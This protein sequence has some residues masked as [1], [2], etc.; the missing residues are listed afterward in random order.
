[1]QILFVGDAPEPE[2]VAALASVPDGVVAAA[3]GGDALRA[4]LAAS[5][6]ILVVDARAGL[7]ERLDSLDAV[8]ADRPPTTPRVVLV[9]R[10]EEADAVALLHPGLDDY[11][12]GDPEHFP[13][14]RS[15]IRRAAARAR[16]LRWTES[17]YE[18]AVAAL[19]RSEA[20]YRTLF[21]AHPSPLWVYDERTLAFLA[22]NQAAVERYGYSRD[23]FLAMT[24]RDIRPEEDREALE[25]HVAA[26]RPARVKAGGWRHRKKDGT[27][28]DVEVSSH[29]IPFDG[30]VARLVVTED[31]TERRRSEEERA[32]L[33]MAVEQA[34][35]AI[36][37]TDPDGTIVYVNPAF[38][39]VT[40]YH[41]TEAR[42]R[43]PRILKSGRQDAAFYAELWST[44]TS[45]ETW[46]G[47]LTNRRKD[48]SLY[49]AEAAISPVRD[50]AG[51][52]VNYVA[53]ERDVTHERHLE[54]QFLQSQKMEAVGRLAG[55]IAH[56]FNNLLNVITG[57]GE[58]LRRR[59]TPEDP[60]GGKLDQILKAADRAAGLVRQ[61]LA[62][63]RRQVLQPK[64][65]DLGLVV[66]DLD[67]MLRRLIGED[68][69]LQCLTD[70][71]LG[72]VRADPGQIEQVLMNLVVNARDAMPGG[73]KITIETRNLDV[74][75]TEARLR[76]SVPPGPYV[77]LAV[78]DTGTGM[79]EET[80]AHVFEPFFT[81]KEPG[82]GT[83][84]GLSTVYGI[85]R[86]SGG[87]ISVYSE[88]GGGTTFKIYLPR[89]DEPAV[90]DATPAP[91]RA[92]GGTETVL[93][94]EDEE[95]VREMLQETLAGAGYRL[96]VAADANHAL[97]R[98]A[99]HR[100][101]IQLLLTDV[102]MPGGSGSELAERLSLVRPGIRVLYVSGYTEEAIVRHGVLA[103]DVA[104]LGKPFTPDELLARVRQLLD[105]AGPTR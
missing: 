51:R 72:T 65:L 7:R 75:E 32:R 96:L 98:A 30:R 8:D 69:D 87:H 89:L 6:E 94:V 11:V 95:M 40:G 63:S 70:P 71:H 81:T 80:L 41:H 78:S 93:L 36:V 62:F 29:R 66:A 99:A 68:V 47:Q 27:V 19:R 77:L 45:G 82:R 57:Y 46:R 34:D 74:G 25:R 55:G 60:S 37:I 12:A 53:V 67:K 14:L 86:Q 22:V 83:G 59:L 16:H 92:A 43:N 2:L 13:C 38:E 91:T 33:A 50:G 73:G 105:A 18:Q 88:P 9:S 104:F 102:V 85:V 15:M 97:A 54:R 44:L 21:D 1:V 58:L 20:W 17:R 84:L 23:E 5:P 56:D 52:I 48:G 103:R 3:G 4:A 28:I 39:R 31:V 49:E 26:D 90:P 100:G 76:A 35:E 24:I 10:S 64:V 79:D 42:G 101:S 61:L